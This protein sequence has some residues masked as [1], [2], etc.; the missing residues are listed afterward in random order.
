[1]KIIHKQ[2]QELIIRMNAVPVAFCC[3][4]A[5]DSWQN[6]PNQKGNDDLQPWDNF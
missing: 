6:Y 4:T 5:K 2:S 3:Q 1:M